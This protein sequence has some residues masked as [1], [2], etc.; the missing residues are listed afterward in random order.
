MTSSKR[1]SS[2]KLRLNPTPTRRR[3]PKQ[4]QLCRIIS[5]Q[6]KMLNSNSTN[7]A[8]LIKSS[9]SQSISITHASYKLQW[10]VISRTQNAE[11][12]SQ[13]IAIYCS[14]SDDKTTCKGLSEPDVTFDNLLH[15]VKTLELT[16]KQ[17]K[18]VCQTATIKNPRRSAKAETT[19]MSSATEAENVSLFQLRRRSWPHPGGQHYPAHG[20]TCTHSLARSQS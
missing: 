2:T 16:D 10:R 13:L 18:T 12:K 20:V 6:D 8:I 15:F 7:F 1:S 9:T 19:S 4:W 5:T 17:H 11:L 14:Y 3:S